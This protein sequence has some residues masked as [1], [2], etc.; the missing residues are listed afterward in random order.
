MARGEDWTASELDAIVSDYFDMLAC[1][2]AGTRYVKTEHSMALMRL[3]D[4]S[5]QSIEF[6]HCNITAVLQEVGEV[7]ILGYKPRVNY[8]KAI[9]DS[10]ERH[11]EGR[12]IVQLTELPIVTPQ[13]IRIVEAPRPILGEVKQRRGIEDLIRR[14]DPVERDLRNRELG[15]AGEKLVVGH[16]RRRLQEAGRGDLAGMVRHVSV[17]VG[18]GL[19]YDI[20]S[21][22][23]DG[24][25]REIEVKTTR[26]TALTPFF[27]SRNERIVSERRK[28]TYRICRVHEFGVKP[29][30]FELRPPIEEVVA[31]LTPEVWRAEMR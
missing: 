10:I 25:R 22:D 31:R 7:G 19:G 27:I 1:E 20:E 11:L 8:Q 23:L 29:S 28:E 16:E 21:F 4:R 15:L 6:K 26:G 3:I 18:D 9:L 5:K 17:E 30:M 12:G 2:K 24:A 13:A 14:F